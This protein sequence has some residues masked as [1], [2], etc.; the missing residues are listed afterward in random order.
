MNYF[1]FLVVLFITLLFCF[2]ETKGQ[3]IRPLYAGSCY[4][5]LSCP[6]N[7]SGLAIDGSSSLLILDNA[8]QLYSSNMRGGRY[9]YFAGSAYSYFVDDTGEM[10]ASFNNPIYLAVDGYHNIYVADCY[11]L[12]VRKIDASAYVHTIAGNGTRG[13]T[14][15]GGLATASEI[16]WVGGIAVDSIGNVYFSDTW[17]GV[18]RKIDAVYGNI[19]TVA[20]QCSVT[21]ASNGD[22]GPASAA[23]FGSPGA[24]CLD[25]LGNLFV[26]D[27]IAYNIRKI[28]TSG[29]I[30][31]IAGNDTDIHG[32]SGDGGMATNAHMNIPGG[33]CVDNEGNV[34]FSDQNW[35]SV[36]EY[37]SLTGN[38]RI[39]KINT[40]GII[41]TV[42][43]NGSYGISGDYGPAT[44]AQL[45]TPDGL[46]VDRNGFIYIA[47]WLGQNVRVID[48]CHGPYLDSIRGLDSVCL[49]STITQTEDVSGGSWSTGDVSIATISSSGVLHGVSS[50]IVSV[51]YSYTTP[52]GP[53][54]IS[55]NVTVNPY[56]GAIATH[57]SVCP[58][59]TSTLSSTV[60]GGIWSS[61]NMAIATIDSSTGRLTAVSAGVVNIS[62][63]VTNSCGTGVDS[64]PVTIF[65]FPAAGTITGTTT[66]CRSGTATLSDTVVGG[67]WSTSDSTLATITSSGV[68]TSGS[69]TGVDT[70]MYTISNICGSASTRRAVT[71]EAPLSAGSVIGSTSVCAG[72]AITLSDTARGGTWSSSST[73]TATVTGSG[74]VTGVIGGIVTI[75]YSVAN[76]CGTATAVHDVTVNP[77]AVAGT[78]HGAGTICEDSSVTLTVTGGAAGGT[79]TTSSAA[80]ATVNSAGLVRGVTGGS[81]TVTYTVTNSCGSEYTTMGI[82][83]TPRPTVAAITGASSICPGLTETLRDGTAGG[84]WTSSST[85]VATVNSSGLVTAVGGGTSTISYTL[86]NSCGSTS[87]TA[88][89]VV[90]PTPVVDSISGPSSV[91]SGSSLALTDASAGGTWSSTNTAIATV[92]ASGLVYGVAAGVDTIK[93]T[94]AYYCG[95]AIASHLVTITPAAYAGTISGLDSICPG[96]TTTLF[97]T[98][99]AGTWSSSNTAAATISSLGLVTG[100]ATGTTNIVYAVTNSCGTVNAVYP[101]EVRSIYTCPEGIASVIRASD[102]LTIFP[103]P[104]TGFFTLQLTSATT[105]EATLRITNLT[106]QLVKEL[107]MMANKPLDIELAQPAGVYLV[108]VASAGGKWMEKV[109]VE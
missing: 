12:R 51:V 46:A 64:L 1:R 81:A 98:V 34:Y 24:L 103:N 29:I 44:A 109:V 50:G 39:R 25:R 6:L 87:A 52:C 83:V 53:I 80:V 2:I 106:G 38:C 58:G 91:C 60:R 10:S 16:S 13:Y 66:I 14:G 96:D 22:G 19:S 70:L 18:I 26:A 78:L 85:A 82:S 74:V 4:G 49:G 8:G 9:S 45:K 41:T 61:G 69:R 63:S 43:G 95:L 65:A 75:T 100:I 56:P 17:N 94:L 37:T 15:D 30:T 28:N 62:Y 90:D 40:S 3:F 27:Q 97:S 107:K 76:S 99:P 31:T 42:A 102:L 23:C 36:G 73:A 48:T 57:S 67:R 5:Y 84:V 21:G 101:F 71:I 68:L 35:F 105:E 54:S 104:N 92:S 79:W 55:K 47:D 88:L 59:D 89:V 72:S 20:G 11:N 108:S 77:L 7:P 33:I 93:Y 32:F 86:T